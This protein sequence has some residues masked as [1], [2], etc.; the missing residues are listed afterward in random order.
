[1]ICGTPTPAVLTQRDR[2][3]TL[4]AEEQLVHL[5]FLEKVAPARPE[6]DKRAIVV[7]H[8]TEVRH[9]ASID[10]HRTL[11]QIEDEVAAPVVLVQEN[12]VV[13]AECIERRGGIGAMVG[14]G[15]GRAPAWR[16]CE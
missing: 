10:E 6:R 5:V 9:V 12:G 13:L 14:M 1:A 3:W 7:E 8:T 11:R 16:G 15:R 4:W 2:E